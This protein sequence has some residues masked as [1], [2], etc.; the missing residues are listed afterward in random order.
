M[1]FLHIIDLVQFIID[2]AAVPI[3]SVEDIQTFIALVSNSSTFA[4]Y[5]FVYIFLTKGQVFKNGPIVDLS[6]FA[7][8]PWATIYQQC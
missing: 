3:P 6:L 2:T 8:Q 7:Q 4:L 1:I 5:D